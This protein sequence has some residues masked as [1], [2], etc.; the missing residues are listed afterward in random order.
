MT[1]VELSTRCRPPVDNLVEIEF[2]PQ[3][4]ATAVLRL[5]EYPDKPAFDQYWASHANR[6]Y[7]AAWFLWQFRHKQFA[8][9]ALK[10][11]QSVPSPD[12][13]MTTLWIGVGGWPLQYDG[14]PEPEVL[15]AGKRLGHEHVLDVLRGS[16][17]GTDP[18]IKPMTNGGWR[19]EG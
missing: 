9:L 1:R 2:Q 18:D 3:T 5:V 15:A 12:R 19:V 14:F 4:V 7:C 17:P 10:D 8:P 13:E 11:I 16:P 6:E